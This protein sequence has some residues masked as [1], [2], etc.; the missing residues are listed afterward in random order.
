M[1]GIMS[2]GNHV[3]IERDYGRNHS[4]LT[5]D[6]DDRVSTGAL[7]MPGLPGVEEPGPSGYRILSWRS[8]AWPR[9]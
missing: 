2:A 6:F 3:E 8:V 1:H 4:K 5:V 9:S 7:E